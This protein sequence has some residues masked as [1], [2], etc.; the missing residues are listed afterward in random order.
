MNI[1]NISLLIVSAVLAVATLNANAA[2]IHGATI[3]NSVSK[4]SS[5]YRADNIINQRGLHAK[6]VSGV[7]DFDSFVAATTHSVGAITEWFAPS[8]TLSEVI[9]FDLGGLF[10]VDKIAIWNEDA[11]GTDT[12]NIFASTDSAFTSATSLGTFN[13]TNNPNRTSYLAQVLAGFNPV[14]A[15]FLR[16]EV[17][18]SSTSV[19]LGE[20][21]FSA[22]EVSAVPLPAA[23]FLFG[24]ALLG[25]LGFR[26]KA[27]TNVA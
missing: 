3:S 4:W 15:Q 16:F 22:T 25:F 23:A 21:A 24:P 12:V 9:E 1:K 8:G 17:S 27:N 18:G 14:I 20:V 5:T 7:T 2:T 10:T 19:A 6:Y 13:L 11:W 26:R